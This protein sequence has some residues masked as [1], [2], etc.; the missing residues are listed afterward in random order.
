MLTFV[1]FTLLATTVNAKCALWYQFSHTSERDGPH[2]ENRGGS[3]YGDT[4]WAM[5]FGYESL[6]Q[7]V[8]C[9]DMEMFHQCDRAQKMLDAY[10][11]KNNLPFVTINC[12]DHIVCAAILPSGNGRYWCQNMDSYDICKFY[13]DTFTNGS[14]TAQFPIVCNL[15]VPLDDGIPVLE[16]RKPH[17]A[18]TTTTTTAVPTLPPNTTVPANTTA[19][20]SGSKLSNSLA[21]VLLL[22]L[23]FLVF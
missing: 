15:A 7:E 11:M 23:L 21:L 6:D 16:Y 19:P 9:N 12:A 2:R 17:I 4:Q 14:G 5:G 8:V 18:T 3:Y 1:F 13:S 10:T 22:V 20:S